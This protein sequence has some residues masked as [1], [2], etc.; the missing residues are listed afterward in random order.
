VIEDQIHKAVGVA[1][2]DALLTRLETEAVAQ[3]Q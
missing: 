1:D 2:Q 3:L